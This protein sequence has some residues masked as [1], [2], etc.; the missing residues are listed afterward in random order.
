METCG[1]LLMRRIG[2]AWSKACMKMKRHVSAEVIH[3]F[4]EISFSSSS[5]C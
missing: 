2:S 4:V 5:I 3:A 1:R